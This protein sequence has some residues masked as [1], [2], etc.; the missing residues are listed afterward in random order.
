MSQQSTN[1]KA[2]PRNSAVPL[3]QQIQD[4]IIHKIR[5]GEWAKGE[6]V[7]SENTLVEDLGVSRMT[8][9]RALRE[10]TQ[11]GY[12]ERVHG[13]GTFVAE[14]PRHAS[15]IEI[16]DIADEIRAQGKVHRADLWHLQAEQALGEVAQRM[17][18]TVGTTLFHIV[19]LHFQNDV[20]I[21]L[22]DR[23]V[24]PQLAPE[25]LTTD[26]ST[27]TPTQYLMELYRPDEMEHIVRAVMPVEE[28][29]EML[30]IPVGEPCLR[31]SRRTWKNAAVVTLAD[32]TYPSTRYDLGARYATNN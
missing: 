11:Q 26:F 22:E 1:L 8:I 3:Y 20:P 23:W 9:N 30:A 6:K 32:F 13:V 29:R 24:N 25:F 19:M 7:P 17:E 27:I 18:V 14:P 21:Q 2:L 10:L 12:L 16:Q 31:L 4:S 5:S 15:L 28:L